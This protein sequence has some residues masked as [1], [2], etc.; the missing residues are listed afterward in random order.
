MFNLASIDPQ[1]LA[2]MGAIFLFFGEVAALLALPNLMRVVV[3]STIAEIGWLL[4]GF[5]LGGDAGSTGAFMHLGYQVVMRG[6]VL[7]TG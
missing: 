7:V 6:L 3:F 1:G 2:W 5:G 4:V